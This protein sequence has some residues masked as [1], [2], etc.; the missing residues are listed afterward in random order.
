ME[1]V[2]RHPEF[3]DAVTTSEAQHHRAKMARIAEAVRPNFLVYWAFFLSI[4]AIPFYE[5][6][7]PGTGERLGVKR[8]VQALILGAIL[9]R[10]RVCVRWI[11]KAFVWF[12]VYCAYRLV[13]GIWLAPEHFRIWWPSTLDLLQYLLPW[14]WF[15]FNVLRY[16][17]FGRIGLWAFAG[18]VSLC[19]ILHIAGIGMS[20][21]DNG[22]EGR[23]TMF[24]Q[25]ANEI[26]EIYA[27][28]FVILVALAL[29]RN[30]R[31]SLR[32]VIPLSAGVVAVALAKSGSR[33]GAMILALGVL[34]LLPQARAFVSRA[35]RYV[36]MLLVAVVFAAVMYQVPTV[37]KRFASMHSESVARDEAR[38]RMAPV[39]YEIF[40]RGPIFG[41]GPDKY[42][43]ELTRRAMPYLTEKQ[44]TISAHNMVL[45]LLVETGIVGLILFSVGW[46]R[47]LLSAWRARSTANGWL[48]LALLLPVTLA[49][50]TISSPIF[51]P[52]FWLAMAIA[53][54][55]PFMSAESQSCGERT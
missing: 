7:L 32:L 51:E 19:A 6:Y 31:N 28:G 54:A 21:V 27:L 53:L 18:G 37:L 34:L 41:T 33:T 26:G 43:Y 48:P 9:T 12:F 15:L 4:F 55:S 10:P 2:S 36:I 23:S 13:A 25:N 1:T 42:Q 14:S 11:P 39:L 40:L 17:K 16:P 47:A 44:Q 8:V 3:S 52:F 22:A 46:S 50:L 24:G 38:G 5:V 20:E 45:L 35:K 49:G 29:F 30:T